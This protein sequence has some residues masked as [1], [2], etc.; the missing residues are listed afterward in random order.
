MRVRATEERCVGVVS[1]F[2]VC[3]IVDRR[4]RVGMLQMYK[5]STSSD[6]LLG[7]MRQSRDVGVQSDDGCAEA[8]VGKDG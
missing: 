5:F 2:P 1:M 4:R 3:V 6:D 8:D 7:A